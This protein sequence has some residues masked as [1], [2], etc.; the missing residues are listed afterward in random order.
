ML[1]FSQRGEPISQ[2]NSLN[3]YRRPRER[4]TGARIHF[5][6]ES[7]RIPKYRDCR[8]KFRETPITNLHS[9]ASTP[10]DI[11][12]APYHFLLA[13]PA[14]STTMP[15]ISFLPF[16]SAVPVST[17][18][19]LG[20]LITCSLLSVVFHGLV[21]QQNNDDYLPLGEA[22]PWWVLSPGRSWKYP[23]TLLTSGWVEANPVEVSSCEL[24]KM[25]LQTI[26]EEDVLC[27]LLAWWILTRR[28]V[29]IVSS[30]HL[31]REPLTTFLKSPIVHPLRNHALLRL[32][33]PRASLGST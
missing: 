5:L 23:W 9:T 27:A 14:R 3:G 4:S 21:S 2:F 17:R 24:M 1:S 13:P 8:Y 30:C 28:H 12:L 6:I 22:E 16:L 7:H 31:T 18:F 19:L 26:K 25:D 33:L 20:T 29:R 10:A 32:S 11:D 15:S